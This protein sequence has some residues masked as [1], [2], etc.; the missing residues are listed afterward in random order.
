MET[1]PP[2]FLTLFYPSEVFHDILGVGG[3]PFYRCVFHQGA[4]RP[5]IL[6]WSYLYLSAG[7]G[8]QDERCPAIFN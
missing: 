3:C 4:H 7:F 2:D 6:L 8:L 1:E 5:G